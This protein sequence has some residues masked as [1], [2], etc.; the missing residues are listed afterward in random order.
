LDSLK[1]LNVVRGGGGGGDDVAATPP[2]KRNISEV[3]NEKI[4]NDTS[5]SLSSSKI[6][7]GIHTLADLATAASALLAVSDDVKSS[8][9]SEAANRKLIKLTSPTAEN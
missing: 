9:F 8:S 6:D 2:H 5:N 7:G 3:L 1:N 4:T